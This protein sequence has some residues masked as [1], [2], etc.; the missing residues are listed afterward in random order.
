MRPLIINPEQ[1]NDIIVRT[2]LPRYP[3]LKVY[4]TEYVRVT[5][6]VITT[7]TSLEMPNFYSSFYDLIDSQLPPEIVDALDVPLW[8]AFFKEAA[9]LIFSKITELCNT[10]ECYFE[11]VDE[12]LAGSLVLYPEGYYH[13]NRQ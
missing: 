7:I 8:T 2:I 4:F 5:D 9:E 3:E 11:S 10:T 13:A 12:T 1:I 6:V